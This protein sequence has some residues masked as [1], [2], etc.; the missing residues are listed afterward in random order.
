MV[1]FKTNMSKRFTIGS[2]KSKT[3]NKEKE[4]K[5]SKDFTLIEL[6]VVIAIIAILASMLL[7]ALNNARESAKKIGCTNNLKQIGTAIV[8]YAGDYD[9]C[10]YGYPG[11]GY[12][13]VG[14]NIYLKADLPTNPP[15][16]IYIC[17]SKQVIGEGCD[18]NTKY[19]SS[20]SGGFAEANLR[21][22]GALYCNTNPDGTWSRKL[23]N[24]LPGSIAIYPK[25][26]HPTILSDYNTAISSSNTNLWKFN[27]GGIKQ[28]AMY[29][30]N[31]TDNFLFIDGHVK[32][33]K[34]GMQVGYK[35]GF[36]WVP[37]S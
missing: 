2:N 6:L 5:Q 20:Y 35:E 1:I 9:G 14:W 7:P 21:G 34:R 23:S 8:F 3:K 29:N 13:A 36:S 4:M 28:G 12:D 16:G 32:A 22:H 18:A 26:W 33:Y 30:H 37:T 24:I 19:Y 27:A 10:S 31:N 25:D 17:P 15:S 11:V